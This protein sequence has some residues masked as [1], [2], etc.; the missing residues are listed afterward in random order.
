MAFLDGCVT[1]RKVPAM[2]NIVI[3]LLNIACAVNDPA[4]QTPCA[5]AIHTLFYLM[6]G[7]AGLASDPTVVRHVLLAAIY[8]VAALSSRRAGHSELSIGYAKLAF[9]HALLGVLAVGRPE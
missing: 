7:V 2:N 5:I 6:G 4:V 3:C 9:L 8:A 1:E